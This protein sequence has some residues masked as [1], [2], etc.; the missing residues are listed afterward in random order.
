MVITLARAK[1]G[2]AALHLLGHRT[3]C[4]YPEAAG[5]RRYDISGRGGSH[6][7]TLWETFESLASA[8]LGVRR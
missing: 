8:S 7:C 2:Q 4:I 3:N 5:N 1:L 6:N